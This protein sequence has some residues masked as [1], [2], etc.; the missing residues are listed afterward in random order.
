MYTDS[1][2][3]IW[4]S[5]QIFFHFQGLFMEHL[6]QKSF[7]SQI[8]SKKKDCMYTSLRFAH[9]G[10]DSENALWLYLQ[11][12]DYIH[13]GFSANF[14]GK[15]RGYRWNIL[16]KKSF[17]S[18][19]KQKKNGLHRYLCCLRGTEQNAPRTRRAQWRCLFRQHLAARWPRTFASRHVGTHRSTSRRSDP[20]RNSSQ[21]CPLRCTSSRIQPAALHWENS[22]AQPLVALQCG[23]TPP[24]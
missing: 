13:M 5:Q 2:T 1:T 11:R 20:G 21:V 23:P 24:P 18:H 4:A 9:M 6:K 14:S 19:M 12:F 16:N 7:K 15:S 10:S 17:K 8:I 3:F 22:R